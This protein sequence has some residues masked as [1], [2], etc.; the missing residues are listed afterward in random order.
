MNVYVTPAGQFSKEDVE[1]SLAGDPLLENFEF[2][3]ISDY[4]AVQPGN[5]DIRVVPLALGTD[6]IN[7]ENQVLPEGLVA[8]VIA[9]QPNDLDALPDNEPTGFGIVLLTN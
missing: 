3:D 6:E 5:Y 9:R 8:T 7:E 4:V 2:A 1:N